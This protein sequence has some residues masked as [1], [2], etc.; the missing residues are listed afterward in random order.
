MYIRF[1][2]L[3][4]AIDTKRGDTKD[5]VSS[6]RGSVRL[7]PIQRAWRVIVLVVKARQR[8]SRRETRV[9][10]RLRM[11][12][13][14]GTTSV[15][16]EIIP[17]HNQSETQCARWSCQPLNTINTVPF[18]I[19]HWIVS[20]CPKSRAQHSVSCTC[21]GWSIERILL[22]YQVSGPSVGEQQTSPSWWGISMPNPILRLWRELALSECSLD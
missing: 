19:F 22:R 16:P 8:S 11:L 18:T 1:T 4:S 14:P 17:P 6:L 5:T 12:R 20:S 13:H 15:S 10:C 3:A 21:M 2:L 7:W 9:A